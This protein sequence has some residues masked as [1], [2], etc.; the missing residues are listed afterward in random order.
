MRSF[1]ENKIKTCECNASHVFCVF[2]SIFD[3][4]FN[5]DV[6][7]LLFSYNQ[8]FGVMSLMK[9]KCCFIGGDRRQMYAAEMLA[10]ELKVNVIGASYSECVKATIC[11]NVSKAVHGCDVIVL[12][13]PVRKMEEVVSFDEVIGAVDGKSVVILGGR[14]SPYMRQLLEE[15]KIR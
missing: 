6:N 5:V 8:R 12:P 9:N 13:L 10:S 4:I 11:G 1:W 14:F 3:I 2:V 15:K 7:L